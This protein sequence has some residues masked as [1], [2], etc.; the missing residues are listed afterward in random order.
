MRVFLL[1]AL[2][3]HLLVGPCRAAE[4]V[5]VAAPATVALGEKGS[6]DLLPRAA[7][8]RDSGGAFPDDAASLPAWRAGL[9]PA[10]AVAATGGA[11]WVVATIRNDTP[12]AN[13]VLYPN[14]TLVDKFEARLY[15]D[16]GSRQRVF[17]G[18]Q[19]SHD[20]MLHYGVD[21]RLQPGRS[22]QLVMRFSS[23]YFVRAPLFA[24]RPQ[25][26]FRRMVARENVVII[27]SL[28][29][30]AA[31]ALY[32]FFIFSFTRRSA[33]LYYSLY[34][35]SMAVG[36]ALP[37]NIFADLYDWHQIEVHYIPFFLLPVFSTLFYLRFLEL[38]T[39]A[40]RLAKISRVNIVLP[41][42]L[43]PSSFLAVGLAHKLATIVLT[44]YMV[45]A[46]ICGVVAWRRGF[47]PARYFV[48]AYIAVIVPALVVMATN[49]GLLPAGDDNMPILVLVG[50]TVDALLLA[51][52]LADQI[53]LLSDQMEQQVAARTEELLTAN[54][55]LTTAKEHAE[56]VSR[57]RI[58]FLSAMSHDIRTPMAGVIGMLKLALRD[59]AVR[60]RTADYL[61]IGLRSGESLLVILN[62]I[63]DYSKI[64][65]GKLTLETTSFDLGR[66]INDATAIL[67][68]Q[69]E[70]KGLTLRAAFED[71]LPRHVIG[72]PTRIRQILVNLLGNA[73]K[74]TDRGEVLLTV[75][76]NGEDAVSGHPTRLIF[77]VHD[78][79]PGIAA[80]VQQRLFQKFEQ[81]DY[82][83]TRRYG[84]T[85]LGLAICKELV[86]L[87][88]GTIGVAST[89]GV[90]S[91]FDV[92][93][94]LVVAGA[95]EIAAET[96][97]L[98]GRQ[99]VPAAAA[100]DTAP[101]PRS[102]RILCA[103]DVATNQIII[104]ALLDAM[105]H[106][107]VIVEDGEAALRALAENDFDLVLM[108]GRMP[109]MDGAQATRLIRAGAG[110]PSAPHLVAR[111][112]S[113]PIIALTANASQDD[114][115]HYL[116]AGMDGFL[117]KPVDE[118]AL[119]AVI[120]ATIAR[121]DGAGRAA[122]NPA[123]PAIAADAG[124]AIDPADTPPERVQLLPVRGL[125]PQ[126]M[127]RIA[128]AFLDEAPRR[129]AEASS[130]LAAGR[131]SVAV[132]AF[133]ALKGSAG[134]LSSPRL[135]QLAASLER[136]AGAGA[137]FAGD[138]ELA[139]LA[140]A[141]DDAVRG[142]REAMEAD[143]IL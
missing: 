109:Q 136:R 45:L 79:G 117:S 118:A 98:A 35:L 119:Q 75:R 99:L 120:A 104:K 67:Q 37:F 135:Q 51:F 139:E 22:Y 94:P 52:A 138:A 50:G 24:V 55:A 72:D 131:Q 29:A 65:A 88:G 142:V 1:L 64:D 63:L 91:R 101:Q 16:D 47:Q 30:L 96:D 97:T 19:A 85:G 61:R 31:L 134:Y 114:C 76:V 56:V 128:S 38:P 68:G 143:P 57:H 86:G 105:G 108:D 39:L 93:L 123:N 92:M 21:V 6:F 125:S 137:L 3:M 10:A 34:V 41:L 83:T 126:Q 116:A 127:R 84:G 8:L 54:V 58:D 2:A 27:G 100:G 78:T 20:Y 74:F 15:G 14:N 59:P 87:M 90:G 13:W 25:A 107:A 12:G 140:A 53:R 23:P 124:D 112:P 89:P 43:L 26:G 5:P 106:R 113:I 70:A 111:N 42:L 103:E 122:A 133:H 17:T 73:I 102:L 130:A 95:A 7:L 115:R 4:G 9:Q 33:Y 40:P 32:N 132:D 121:L 49:L 80:E 18:F 46:L 110:A 36:W 62:D 141:V 11:Y 81:G 44:F 71:A 69:A 129:L 60:G 66:L 48:L 77:S 28:G 82:S